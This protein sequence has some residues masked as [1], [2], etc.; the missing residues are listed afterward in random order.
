[1]IQGV[2]DAGSLPVIEQTLKF[3]GSRHRLILHNIANLST[4]NFQPMDVS[5]TSFQ[6]AL[7]QAIDARRET[8][9]VNGPLDMTDTREIQFGKQTTL[10]PRT[11]SG[12]I[13][14]HDR[15]NRSLERTMQNLAE[16]ALMFRAAT[17]LF[18]NRMSL[19][20]TAIRERV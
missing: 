18:R 5:P 14:F 11:A 19:I 12:N 4:P 20:N 1:M 3:T 6:D 10:K 13:L 16:N 9:A 15:N 7:G 8:G 17:T 2:T